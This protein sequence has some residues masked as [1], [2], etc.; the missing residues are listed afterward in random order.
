MEIKHKECF[1]PNTIKVWGLQAISKYAREAAEFVNL[2][3]N[4]RG[5]NRFP[6]LI[7]VF[8]LLKEREEVI[9]RGFE[10]PDIEPLKCWVQ[11]TKDLSN[12]GLME[13]IKETKDPILLRA[14]E[15]SKSVNKTIEDFVKGCSS[16]SLCPRKS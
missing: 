15:W 6:A 2:Y 1:T 7:Q 5:A 4:T 12:N 14:L 3:S 8:D 10:L 13:A 9:E 11:S 16:L